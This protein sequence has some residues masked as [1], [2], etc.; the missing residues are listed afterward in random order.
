MKMKIKRLKRGGF[1]FKGSSVLKSIQDDNTPWVDLLVRESIQNVADEILPDSRFGKVEFTTGFFDSYGLAQSLETVGPSLISRDGS[2]YTEPKYP[3]LAIADSKTKGLLGEPIDNPNGPNNL[4]SLV[5]DFMNNNKPTAAGGSWGIGKSVYYRFGNGLVFY[6]SRTHENGNYIHKLAGALIQDEKKPFCLLGKDSSG[7]AFFGDIKNVDGEEKPWPIY[8][9]D[10]IATFLSLFGL[11]PYDGTTTGTVVIIPYFQTNKML[12]R[13]N[14]EEDSGA[15]WQNDFEASLKMSI[16]RWW[17]PRLNNPKFGPNDQYFVVAVDGE[18]V[19]LNGFYKA[20]QDIY[21]GD[22]EGITPIEIKSKKAGTNDAL[23]TLYCGKLTS[24]QLN[25]GI[26]PTPL[27]N[28]Y[29]LIDADTSSEERNPT[30][31]AYSRNLGMIVNYDV[32]SFVDVVSEGDEYIFAIFK[33]NETAKPSD[34]GEKALGAYMRESERANHKSWSDPNKENFPQ[35][36]ASRPFAK[37][38]KRIKGYLNENFKKQEEPEEVSGPSALRRKLGELLLPPEDFGKEPVKKREGGSDGA[39]GPGKKRKSKVSFVGYEGR[40][41]KYSV[42]VTLPKKRGCTIQSKVISGSTQYTLADWE[43]L[44]FDDPIEI[45]SVSVVGF[46]N[47]DSELSCNHRFECREWGAQRKIFY[48]NEDSKHFELLRVL[49]PSSHVQAFRL[50][51]KSSNDLKLTL[52]ILIK[53]LILTYKTSLET[54]ID[55]GSK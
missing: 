3:F 35:F 21:N 30:I 14:T 23:G 20:L 36:S 50:E 47:K 13:N 18:K 16:Q 45:S 42:V 6:Y 54:L 33:L 17:F 44:R 32:E 8:D 9:E 28:P 53:P 11:K 4:Y 46:S 26:P 55:G 29:V 7:I 12:S 5:Y 38:K 49:T 10:E 39:G 27:P 34:S 25:I 41:L 52:E 51:N 48:K 1:V 22:F 24:K 31:F 15:F 37:I 2:G 43:D 40:L 19:E